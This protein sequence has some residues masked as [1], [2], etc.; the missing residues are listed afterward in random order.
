M[1]SLKP[2][3]K[4]NNSNSS[5]ADEEL[6]KS[7][8]WLVSSVARSLRRRL[9]PSVEFADLVGY[10]FMGLLD[11]ST[12]FDSTKGVDFEDYARKRIWGAILDGLRAEK[13]LPRSLMAKIRKVHQAID[14][15]SSRLQRLPDQGEVADYLGINTSKYLNILRDIDSAQVLSL[16]ALVG[17]RETD[18]A[19][20]ILESLMDES[21]P[22]P[23]E[24][25]ERE[26]STRRLYQAIENLPEREKIVLVLYYFDEL[27][28]KEIGE[29]MDISESRVSQL[30]SSALRNLRRLLSDDERQT[31]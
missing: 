11:A 10:G 17:H 31:A 23:L 12:R 7:Y 29:V 6:V 22:D 8:S 5:G 24:E 19:L 16:E 13:R 20:D 14:T 28:M 30:H 25:A 26:E 21:A 9:P 18:D 1:G 15:L 2:L 27:S 3:E 4:A